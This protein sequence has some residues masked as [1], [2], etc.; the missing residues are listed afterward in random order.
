MHLYETSIKLYHTDA[1]GLLFFSRLFEIAY[2]AYQ[3]LLEKSRLSLSEIL[4]NE[5]FLTPV[6]HAEADY[7][8]PL[9]AGDRIQV[10]ITVENIGRSSCTLLYDIVKNNQIAG[11]VKTVLVSVDKRFGEKTSIPEKLKE[12]LIPHLKD[13]SS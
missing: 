1:A 3:D 5:P 10:R 6:V 12:V 13:K 2:D 11:R 7:R 4:K 9:E 8:I